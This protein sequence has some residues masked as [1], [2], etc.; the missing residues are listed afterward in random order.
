MWRRCVSC[1]GKNGV[2]FCDCGSIAAEAADTAEGFG[3]RRCRNIGQQ[4]E[5]QELLER[6]IELGYE[7]T[8]Q[9]DAIGQ[10]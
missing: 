7:R 10:F 6:L 1:R 2:S 9:V 4:L 3:Q 5:Q 8:T